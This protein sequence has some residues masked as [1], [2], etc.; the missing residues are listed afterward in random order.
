TEFLGNSE[1]RLRATY[2]QKLYVLDVLDNSQPGIVTRVGVRGKYPEGF[3][4]SRD[5]V[6]N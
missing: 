6:M 3:R 5:E 1:K 2:L 4:C